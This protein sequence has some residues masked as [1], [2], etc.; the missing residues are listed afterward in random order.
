MSVQTRITEVTER[1]EL[2]MDAYT[3]EDLKTTF[4]EKT[5]I[6]SRQAD[7]AIENA[8]ADGEIITEDDLYFPKCSMEFQ[9]IFPRIRWSTPALR[10]WIMSGYGRVF[11]IV[12]EAEFTTLKRKYIQP[13]SRAGAE[14]VMDNIRALF[15]YAPSRRFAGRPWRYMSDRF[16]TCFGIDQVITIRYTVI[17]APPPAIHRYAGH[18]RWGCAAVM[19]GK[20]R[21]YRNI[22]EITVY[23]DTYITD[24]DSLDDIFK[25]LMDCVLSSI[26]YPDIDGIIDTWNS[27]A[28]TGAL[29][30]QFEVTEVS[31]PSSAMEHVDGYWEYWEYDADSGERTKIVNKG[32][33][34]TYECLRGKK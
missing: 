15:E 5:N 10:S 19:R 7:E 25:K 6:T 33:I 17:R 20:D 34:D 14:T 28:L 22:R 13:L 18:L 21:K 2:L 31:L 27:D 12:P 32:E 1:V 23:H 16:M 30:Q 3:R 26:N 29:S 4:I 9:V 24:T 8:L 11:A